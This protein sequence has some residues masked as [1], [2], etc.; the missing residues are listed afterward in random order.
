MSRRASASE[1]QLFESDCTDIQGAR[2]FVAGVF[3]FIMG[4]FSYI[5]GVLSFITGV[6]VICTD[7]LSFMSGAFS[8]KW[9][10]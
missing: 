3:I 7:L 6:R 9:A 8:F 2:R 10:R 5:M 4:V 1:R